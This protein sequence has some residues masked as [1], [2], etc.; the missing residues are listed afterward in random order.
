MYVKFDD[1]Q[2]INKI[3]QKKVWET[4]LNQPIYTGRKH[5]ICSPFRIDS[6]PNC[7]IDGDLIFHDYKYGKHCNA[8]QA[9][10]ELANVGFYDA[11]DRLYRNESFI[12]EYAKSTNTSVNK[13]KTRKI[14][15]FE[16][17]KTPSK[18]ALDYWKLRGF[19]FS[20]VHSDNCQ[21]FD[22]KTVRIHNYIYHPLYPCFA[23][24]FHN[25]HTKIYIPNEDKNSKWFGDVQVTD[26]W[27][28]L[29]FPVPDTCI[30]TKSFKDGYILSQI[31]KTL[32]VY[33]FQGEGMYCKDTIQEIKSLYKHKYVI[34]DNDDVG[35]S[36]GKV[37]ANMVNGIEVYYP[38]WM[39]KDTDDLLL[40]Y[41]K[42]FIKYYL[43][44]NFQL[45]EKSV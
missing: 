37:I 22:V 7:F 41:S 17:F 33:V 16:A 12:L 27:K 44:K 6:K 30:I 10:A 2:F 42:K 43:W 40:K 19:D 39:G 45:K 5:K 31:Y 20:K 28:W 34:Y 18:K 32:D 3:D 21:M 25:G 24:Q 1:K 23:Y 15:D 8:I 35:Y 9:Y 14:V 11:V 38:E 4:I 36:N 13:L 29:R 26:V